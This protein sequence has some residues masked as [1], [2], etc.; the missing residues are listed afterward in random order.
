MGLSVLIL[1]RYK[2]WYRNLLNAFP[3]LA[4]DNVVSSILSLTLRLLDPF[5]LNDW[6]GVSR[7][8]LCSS[9][10]SSIVVCATIPNGATSQPGIISA[11]SFGCG[12]CQPLSASPFNM[13]ICEC[14]W[15][16]RLA[17]TDENRSSSGMSSNGN[18]A[19]SVMRSANRPH[20]GCEDKRGAKRCAG[21]N[22]D[23]NVRVL[24]V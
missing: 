22:S 5:G 1:L 14:S 2:M 4:G 7:C 24:N 17:R 18:A 9:P 10:P 15:F 12:R 13:D 23:P 19:P 3:N 6:S 20:S 16:A 21:R 11:A 8:F